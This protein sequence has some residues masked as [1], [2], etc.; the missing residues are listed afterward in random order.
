MATTRGTGDNAKAKHW[1]MVEP[2][3]RPGKAS[4]AERARRHREAWRGR[5]HSDSTE[6]IREDCDRGYDNGWS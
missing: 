6:L 3:L 5:V 2:G 4:F 1:P